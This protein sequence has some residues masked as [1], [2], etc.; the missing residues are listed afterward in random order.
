MR[1]AESNWPAW[2]EKADHDLLC[3][4]NNLASARVPWDVVCYHAQQAA[5]KM[6]KAFLVSHGQQPRRTHDLVALLQEC[7]SLDSGFLQLADDCE[8]LNAFSIDAR[9]PDDLF[10]AG[11][12]EGRAAVAAAERVVDVL[13]R[14]LPP[15]SGSDARDIG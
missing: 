11:G 10:K 5:E 4:H 14:R 12:T 8:A 6:L 15:A 2:V 3:I 13:R 7:A 9:Y 1:S